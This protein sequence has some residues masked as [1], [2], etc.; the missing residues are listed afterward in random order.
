MF[1][2][3]SMVSDAD[4]RVDVAKN[5]SRYVAGDEEVSVRT[6]TVGANGAMSFIRGSRDRTAGSFEQ[7]SSHEVTM[8]AEESYVENV[9]GGVH[10]KAA[11]GAEAMIG[12]AY[13]HT[14]L[15]PYMRLAGWVDFMAWGG[16]A[17]VDAIRLELSLLM[18]RS[19]FG[20]AHAAGLRATMA[21]RL[22]DDFQTRTILLSSALAI[23]GATYMEVGDPAGG[24]HNEV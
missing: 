10:V 11:L 21:S 5:Y 7:I 17:D 24:I 6:A 14:I 12:G 3:E 1:R 2:Y 8:K 4:L 19:H 22:I 9:E 20:Y 23:N 16:W 13:A 18:I 15:G